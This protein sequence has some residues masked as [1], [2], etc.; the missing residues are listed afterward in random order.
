MSEESQQTADIR[1]LVECSLDG[2]SECEFLLQFYMACDQCGWWGSLSLP[3]VP[4]V[5]GKLGIYC[6]GECCDQANDESVPWEVSQTAFEE[7]GVLDE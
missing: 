5:R 1:H 2:C 6:R 4:W 3:E 7:M